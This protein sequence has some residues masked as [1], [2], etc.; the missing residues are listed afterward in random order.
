[1]GKPTEDT[2]PGLLVRELSRELLVAADDALMVGAKR[3]NA[4]TKGLDIGHRP[5]ALGQMRSF[6]M[7]ESLHR[8]F[9]VGGICPNDI[10]G[11]GILKGRSGLFTLARFNTSDRNWASG[12]RSSTRRSMSQANRA[13]EPL[14]QK[15]LF[16]DYVPAT[17]GVVFLVACFSGSIDVQPESPLSI[18]IAV[19]DREMRGWL[20]AEPIGNFLK[21]YDQVT[22]VQ[23]DLAVP[24]LKKNVGVKIDREN[25]SE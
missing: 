12:R 22:K 16:D 5:H 23:S 19:P 14:V 17:E 18:H 9:E 2:I 8:A 15:S 7:N 3:A 4:D 1:M 20:F 25:H 6:L 11:N 24:K 13:L 10:R 21:R